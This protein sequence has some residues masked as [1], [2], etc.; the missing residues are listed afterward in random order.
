VDKT[1]KLWRVTDGE[2]VRTLSGFRGQVSSVA[3]S[4][5]GTLVMGGSEDGTVRLYSVVTGSETHR[6]EP[7]ADSV[8]TVGFSADGKLA[9]SGSADKTVK[10]WSVATG[11]LV[12][13]LAGHARAVASIAFSP[14]GNVIA[15]GSADK[16]V[17]LWDIHTGRKLCSLSGHSSFIPFVAF[18]R[19]GKVLASGS[20]DGSVRLWAADGPASHELCELYSFSDD[21]W[22]V[23]D[24][25]GRYDAANGGE[26]DGLHWVLGK[27]P[28][29]LSQFKD[30]Y[31]EPGLLA[32]LL[33]FNSEPVRRVASITDLQLYPEIQVDPLSPGAT[34][35][36]VHLKNR[37]GGIGPV[38]VYIN[39]KLAIPDAR[40]G[41]F[42]PN[43]PTATLPV[44]L[45]DAPAA[46][47]EDNIIQV[48]AST[49]R[50]DLQ[51][52]GARLNW[53]APGSKATG[54]PQLYAV[55]AGV[56]D[57]AETA[58]HL[59]FAAKDAVDVAS[60]LSLAG[61]RLL[62]PERVHLTLLSSDTKQVAGLPP[63]RPATR[64]EFE[65][66][67]QQVVRESKP[68]DIVVVYLS[69]HG[70]AF[71]EGEARSRYAYLTQD[72]RTTDLAGTPFLKGW[73]VTGDDL[74]QWLHNSKARKQVLILDTCAAGALE[75]ELTEAMRAS[76]DQIRAMERLK[77]RTGFHIL[78]GCAANRVSY[79]T[80]QYWQGLLTY[81]LLEGMKGRALRGGEFV[82]VSQWFQY[83]RDRVPELAR[84]IR[85]GLQEPQI[86][87]PRGDSFDVGELS[88]E[89][90]EHIPLHHEVPLLCP[91]TLLELAGAVD[92]LHLAPALL[93]QLKSRQHASE[94]DP[95]SR[96][97]KWWLAEGSLPDALLLSGIY[98]VE[99]STVKVH[100][101][102]S[103]KGVTVG[104]REVSGP[105]QDRAKDVP[106]LAG[107]LAA[108]VEDVLARP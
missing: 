15:S 105:V 92:T 51:S 2:L 63:P 41:N 61:K 49:A 85:L 64:Q 88:S 53:V 37:G 1:I 69:G 26:V 7:Q 100:L 5:D 20:E 23:V 19:I 56:S 107:Q 57:Y 70:V 66:A 74:F 17:K 98:T 22:A 42:D 72:A 45:P 52:R 108:A 96:P 28:I 48:A 35:L 6:L 54:A 76:A 97:P 102:L 99:D 3:F 62:T 46:A 9:A 10:L 65:A 83:A 18:S 94:G 71:Q 34:R 84:Q 106:A 50:G 82:D 44:D 43:Q 78:M 29:V 87:A 91:P 68:E 81:A 104:E 75:R 4:P 32:K 11:K 89:D 60:A 16:T 39:G 73:T 36:T 77:D 40:P 13:T 31:Y 24:P 21:T 27:E 12:R 101:V 80:S 25:Q 55:I 103:Q 79:E 59:H 93:E 38:E 47:G 86:A 90:R 95:D 14:D 33:R 8:W 30:G 58:L 67:F